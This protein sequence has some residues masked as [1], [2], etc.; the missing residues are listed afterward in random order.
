MLNLNQAILHDR[1]SLQRAIQQIPSAA[2]SRTDR[3]QSLKLAILPNLLNNKFR[4]SLRPG[5]LPVF[6]L[7]APLHGHGLITGLRPSEDCPTGCFS[8][9]KRR[10]VSAGSPS[11]G[12]VG[13]GMLKPSGRK[14][15]STTRASWFWNRTIWSG[16]SGALPL[17]ELHQKTSPESSDWEAPHQQSPMSRKNPASSPRR[18]RRKPT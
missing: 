8:G 14:I 15:C 11:G 12:K 5:I 6:G 17:P 2:S 10:M 4:G 9:K 3:A 1:P 16:S 18:L 7:E 13:R